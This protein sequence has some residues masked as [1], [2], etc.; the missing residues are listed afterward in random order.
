VKV[1]YDEDGKRKSATGEGM[2]KGQYIEL[3]LAESKRRKHFDR[4]L[5]PWH[6]VS[7]VIIIS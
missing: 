4:V 3:T 6:V 7:K 5:I 1:M 2:D